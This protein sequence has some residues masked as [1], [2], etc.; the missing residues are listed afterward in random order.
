MAGVLSFGRMNKFLLVVTVNNSWLSCK[1]FFRLDFF[2][3]GE[4]TDETDVNAMGMGIGSMVVL[5][6]GRD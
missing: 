4:D 1:A 2:G 6:Q 3:V 5:Q